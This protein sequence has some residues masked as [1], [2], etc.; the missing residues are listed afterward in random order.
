M[1][2]KKRE[3][4]LDIAMSAG[5][6]IASGAIDIEDSRDFLHNAVPEMADMY[7]SVYSPN[8]GEDYM[9]S[10]D[11]FADIQLK[12]RYGTDITNWNEDEE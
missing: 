10:I 5:A 7:L 3:I 12:S 6:L 4:E 8:I 11:T 1:N 2:M 9:E